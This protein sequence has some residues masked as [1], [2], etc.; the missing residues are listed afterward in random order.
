LWEAPLTGGEAK[1]LTSA[2]GE[3]RFAMFSPDGR[4]IAFSGNYDGNTDVYVMAANGGEPRRLTYHPGA[5]W[6]ASW[7]PDGKI[8]YRNY[9]GNGQTCYEIFTIG[10]SGAHQL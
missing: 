8:A 1:R 7:T 10:R 6:V 2:K 9:S 4:W 3:E 5:D